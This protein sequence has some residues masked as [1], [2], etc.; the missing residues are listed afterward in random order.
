MFRFATFLVAIFVLLSAMARAET[1]LLMA[2]EDGCYWCAR[3]HDEIA[4]TYPKTDEGM[5]APLRRYDIR[6]GSHRRLSC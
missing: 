6:D 1:V 4:D 5:R 3:W 2:E